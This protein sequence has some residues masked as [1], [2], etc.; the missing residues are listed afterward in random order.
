MFLSSKIQKYNKEKQQQEEN[1]EEQSDFDVYAMSS[2]AYNSSMSAQATIT[3]QM[4]LNG[5]G[6]YN[7][8]RPGI[9]NPRGT[10][11]ELIAVKNGEGRKVDNQNYSV[12]DLSKNAIVQVYKGPKY[13]KN[14]AT[15]LWTVIDNEE[16][17]IVYPTDIKTMPDNK[18]LR[19]GIY[20]IKE[21]LEILSE[22]IASR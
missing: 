21:G 19:V 17:A 14:S 11:K 15:I 9:F 4:T 1:R 5:F 13:Y 6:I 22:V 7:C 8:D 12:V 20:S 2:I 10:I 3:R 16:M 18:K